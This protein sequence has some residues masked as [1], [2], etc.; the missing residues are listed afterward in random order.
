MPGKNLN[1]QVEINKGR[2]YIPN[3]KMKLIRPASPIGTILID[4]FFL[5]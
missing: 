2:G 4:G 1:I 5:P 3:E